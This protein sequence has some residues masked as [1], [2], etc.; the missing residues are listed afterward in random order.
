M[1]KNFLVHKTQIPSSLLPP[2]NAFA[3][4]K[5]Q[6]L[7][8]PRIRHTC[9]LE[10][11]QP[12]RADSGQARS[13]PSSLSCHILIAERAGRALVLETGLLGVDVVVVLAGIRHLVL[14]DLDEAVEGHGCDGAEAV[15]RKK[16]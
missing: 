6:G 15:W 3:P 9:H 4:R 14:E 5:K 2:R 10:K 12:A 7:G 13:K 8:T 16:G 1:I 11:P